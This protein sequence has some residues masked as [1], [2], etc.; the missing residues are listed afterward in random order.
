VTETINQSF[1]LTAE[2]RTMSGM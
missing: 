1:P 2:S